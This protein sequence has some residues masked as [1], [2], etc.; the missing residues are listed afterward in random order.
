MAKAPAFQLYASD[1]LVDTITWDLDVLGFYCRLLYCEWA[2]GP[3][4]KDIKKLAKIAGI[5]PK[6]AQ[7]LYQICSSKFVQ[8]EEGKIVNLRLEET[9]EKQTKYIENQRLKGK[10]RAEQKLATATATAKPRLQPRSQPEGSSS[11]PTPSPT[12]KIQKNIYGEFVELSDDEHK[13]L[14]EKFNG[15]FQEVIEIFNLKIGSMGL[16]EWRKKHKSDYS[17]GLYWDRQGWIF[18]EKKQGEWFV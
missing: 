12:P 9:R 6:K 16:K 3:L 15:K 17:T 13:K 8:T 1:F 10:K 11:S 18:S 7:N 14:S 2:N 5:S 4:E